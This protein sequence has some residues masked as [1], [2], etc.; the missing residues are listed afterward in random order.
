LIFIIDF[1]HR[2]QL[3]KFHQFHLIL[4]VLAAARQIFNFPG[5]ACQVV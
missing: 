3:F 1:D 4:V 2:L 5:G